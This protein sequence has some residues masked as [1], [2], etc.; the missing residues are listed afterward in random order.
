MYIPQ[1]MTALHSQG[2]LQ[3]TWWMVCFRTESVVIKYPKQTAEVRPWWQWALRSARPLKRR[4]GIQIRHIFILWWLI[5]LKK[6]KHCTMGLVKG[7][8]ILTLTAFSLSSLVLFVKYQ[9]T[10]LWMWYQL[11]V[12]YFITLM[13]R[14]DLHGSVQFDSHIEN[15]NQFPWKI[16]LENTSLLTCSVVI[17]PRVPHPFPKTSSKVSW[18]FKS[19]QG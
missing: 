4:D 6:V 8:T 10:T 18:D 19:N 7:C 5:F 15:L 17:L 9:E 2:C 13:E 14:L 16:T 12:I 1:G 3:G 11:I